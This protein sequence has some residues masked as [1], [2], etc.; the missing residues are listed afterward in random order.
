MTSKSNRLADYALVVAGVIVLLVSAITHQWRTEGL[1]FGA[2]YKAATRFAEGK[3][4]YIFEG[5]YAFKY[6]P[7]TIWYFSPFAL[8]SYTPAR[9]LYALLHFAVAVWIPWGIF[10]VFSKEY[11]EAR[12]LPWRSALLMGF[13]GSFRFV[14]GEFRDSNFGLFVYSAVVA[15][16][17]VVSRE[18]SRWAAPLILSLGAVTKVHSLIGLAAFRLTDRKTLLAI[19]FAL[20]VLAFFPSPWLWLDWWA[21]LSNTGNVIPLSP[22]NY[23][24]Q[25]IYPFAMRFLDWDAH[26]HRCLVLALP[27]ALLAFRKLPRFSLGEAHRAPSHFLLTSSVWILLGVM[28]SPLPWQHTY[29]VLWGILPIAFLLANHTERILLTSLSL[30]L[31][32][33]PRDLVGVPVQQFLEF[34]QSVFFAVLGIW[35]TALKIANRCV[36]ASKN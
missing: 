22:Q 18:R 7:L 23:N 12:A 8:L 36:L 14:D 31:C 6:A 2:Y 21:Q 32:F 4:F 27:L 34:N 35:F 19:A 15:S 10:R 25:G 33:S 11:K 13:L 24:L 1:D 9:W 3:P 26:S 20:L 16:A 28:A 5:E 30:F 17:L 29:A